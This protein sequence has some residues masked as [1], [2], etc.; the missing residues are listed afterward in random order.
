MGYF[1]ARAG[2]AMTIAEA[3]RADMSLVDC[4]STPLTVA[5][6][7]AECALLRH[8]FGPFELICGLSLPGVM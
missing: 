5:Y 8:Y 2:G 7:A 6:A 3:A 1:V 4:L